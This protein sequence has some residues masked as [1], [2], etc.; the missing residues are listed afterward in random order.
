MKKFSISQPLLKSHFCISFA[1]WMLVLLWPALNLSAREVRFRVITTT[2]LHGTLVPFDFIQDVPMR[3]SLANVHY[4]VEIERARS[5]QNII[6]LDNGDILQGQ[7]TAYYFNFVDTQTPHI[8]GRAMNLMRFDAA[9]IGNHDIEAGPEVYNRLTKQFKFPWLG[10]NILDKETG[11]PYFKPYTI[12][13]RQGVRIAIL[14][15]ITP[16]VPDWLPEKLWEGMA[17][18]DMYSAA[19]QWVAYL[20]EHEKPDAIIGLFHSGGGPLPEEEL[21]D[22][23]RE[24]TARYIARFVPGFDVIFTGHDHQERNE[25]IRNIEGKEVLVIGGQAYGQSVA[26][27]DL[28]FRRT[29]KRTY[30]L[31]KTTGQLVDTRQFAPSRLFMQRFEKDIAKVMEYVTQSIG[32]FESGMHSRNALW[33]NSAFTDF[34]HQ[35]QLELTGAEISFTAPLSFDATIARGQVKMRDM[36]KLYRYEN[37]LYTM[38]L[39]GQEVKDFLEYSANLWFNQMQ[40]ENDYLLVYRRDSLG[41]VITND[42]GRPSLRN[43]FFN[44]DSAA[45]IEYTIDVSKPLGERVSITGMQSG[46]AFDP[47]RMYKVA[48]NSY[49]GSGGGGH[50][51]RG[52][53]IPHDQLTERIVFVSERDLRSQ[54]ADLLKE[55]KRTNPKAL[56]NWKLLPEAWVEKAREREETL[57]FGN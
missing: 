4:Y 40:D 48:V 2:D 18:Q 5:G 43:P 56:E 39:S 32:Y 21:A 24:H 22:K 25:V 10:A 23:P 42:A 51:T 20:Q 7:P 34:V 44:F 53:G 8:I 33:G 9:T 47:E 46:E 19:R 6:L 13:R 27:A 57:L 31:E 26:V 54:M 11:E 29:D 41:E 16:S 38:T 15:L 36:F 37:Y 17:F 1:L 28:S 14:G 3:G 49:R 12:I 45:G 35:V 50:L 52:A 30:V 55:Q